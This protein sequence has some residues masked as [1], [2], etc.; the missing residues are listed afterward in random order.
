MYIEKK[1]G[2]LAGGD[3]RIGRVHF[4]KTRSTLYYQELAFK[5]LKGGFKA[6]YY[7]LETREQYWIS[8]PKRNGE[9][10]LY[11]ERVPIL[12]DEDVREE[13]WTDIRKLPK[14]RKLKQFY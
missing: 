2:S 1:S 8:G 7:E 11:G 3:A 14:N 4:S 9:D 5:S 10:R 12:I 6:N 13:Y